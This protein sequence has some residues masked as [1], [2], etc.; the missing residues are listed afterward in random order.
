MICPHWQYFITLDSDLKE[1][2]RYVDIGQENF[3]TFSIEFVRLLL[4]AGSEIDVVAKLLCCKID[5]SK[6]YKIIDDYR[7]A[8]MTRFPKYYSVIIDIPQYELHLTPWQDW[9]C[10]KNPSWWK[11]YNNVKHH[12]DSNFKDANLENTINAV[13][14]LFVMILYL[15][16][17]DSQKKKYNNPVLLSVEK[18]NEGF[19]WLDQKIYVLP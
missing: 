19:E 16:S 8:I 9:N 11:A 2:S 7:D 13:A 10:G 12:R 6:E 15:H 4:A 1:A 17:M 5:P 3:S 18:Y 14:G